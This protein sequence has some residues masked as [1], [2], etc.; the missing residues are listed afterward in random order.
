MGNGDVVTQALKTEFFITVDHSENAPKYIVEEGKQSVVYFRSR[1]VII[2]AG[3]KQG[4]H[5]NIFEWFPNL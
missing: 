4:F 3:A 2:G 1:A 5:P